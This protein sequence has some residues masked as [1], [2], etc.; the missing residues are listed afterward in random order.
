VK[1]VKMPLFLANIDNHVLIL[2]KKR[3]GLF[4]ELKTKP[5]DQRLHSEIHDLNVKI[6]QYGLVAK[7]FKK[8]MK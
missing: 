4:L 5:R 3:Q 1:S 6:V 8:E 7:A 2:D